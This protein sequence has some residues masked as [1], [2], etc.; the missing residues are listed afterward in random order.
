M[1][2]V[3]GFVEG[4]ENPAVL[5]K[6]ASRNGRRQLS[7][8]RRAMMEGL[9]FMSGDTVVVV[10]MPGPP[11]APADV[12]DLGARQY[13]SCFIFHL[14]PCLFL[15]CV[16]CV[17]VRFFFVFFFC[18]FCVSCFVSFFVLFC[19]CFVCFFCVIFVCACFFLRA[20]DPFFLSWVYHIHGRQ[21]VRAGVKGGNLWRRR[22]KPC[23]YPGYPPP[24][25][26]P[27]GRYSL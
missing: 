8:M 10:D 17:C 16:K 21:A 19:V 27:N 24:P 12:A 14:L 15:L 13:L 9:A 18:V 1:Q 20:S 6:S 26:S 25:P 2:Y 7:V 11:T 4:L 3:H 5:S 23:A 22:A